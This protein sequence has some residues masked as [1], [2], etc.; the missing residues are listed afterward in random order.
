M[1]NYLVL[2]SQPLRSSGHDKVLEEMEEIW[3]VYGL[4]NDF[5]YVEF[6]MTDEGETYPHIYAYIKNWMENN[7]GYD[8]D[9]P[10]L[11]HYWW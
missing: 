2:D 9:T 5:S 7:E 6:D 10:I 4:G 8:E 3:A 1:K 11:I